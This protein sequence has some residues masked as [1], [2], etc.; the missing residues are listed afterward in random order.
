ML[1]NSDSSKPIYVQISEW[2]EAEILRGH[3]ATDQKVYSQYQLA[4]KFNINPATAGKGL[5]LLV[6]ENILYKKRGLGMFVAEDAREKI[7][8]KRKNQTLK[9]LIFDLVIE[10]NHLG[11]EE[12]ELMQ[13]IKETKRKG[14]VQ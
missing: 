8:S 4:D 1:L 2:L 11:V 6:D 5:T 7:M 14:E 3:F 10:A 13:M 12:E 9:R